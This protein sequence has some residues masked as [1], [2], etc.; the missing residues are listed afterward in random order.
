MGKG[1]RPLKIH[2][3]LEDL[4]R[5]IDSGDLDRVKFI[6][7]SH[8]IDAYD[9][10]YRTTLIL[11]VT[12][13]KRQI[14]DWLLKEKANINN[15]D[16]NGYTCLHFCGQ[17]K[18]EEMTKLLLANGADPNLPDEHGNSPLWTAL[19]NAKGDFKVVKLL[20]ENGADARLKNLYNRSPDDMAKTMYKASIDELIKEN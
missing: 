14:V 9:S 2:K 15:R 11:A 7:G 18:H 12:S 6:C 5:I 19:F 17:E 1:G 3:D 20:R 4:S 16:R 10:Y 13:N 8:G